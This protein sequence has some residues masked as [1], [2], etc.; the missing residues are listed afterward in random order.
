VSWAFLL[1]FKDKL[2]CMEVWQIVLICILMVPGFL[3]LNYYFVKKGAA[4]KRSRDEMI[5][6]AVS[7]SVAASFADKS[8]R[9]QNWPKY[10]T[11]R[12]R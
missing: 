6:R 7:D 12:K 9:Y 5:E 2:R 1:Y 11:G 10:K 3:A 8:A 4:N